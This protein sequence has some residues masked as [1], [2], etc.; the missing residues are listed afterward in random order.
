LLY[1][2]KVSFNL[3]LNLSNLWQLIWSIQREKELEI[4]KQMK[5]FYLEN[6]IYKQL[7]AFLVVKVPVNLFELELS[8][9]LRAI[10]LIDRVYFSLT[11]QLS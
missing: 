11:Y 6:I 4:F 5:V 3:T 7:M 9:H 8:F 1:P 2:N 10:F